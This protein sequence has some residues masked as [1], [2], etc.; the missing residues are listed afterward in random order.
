M[1]DQIRTSK[2]SLPGCSHL[3]Y[4]EGRKS[5]SVMQIISNSFCE[6]SSGELHITCTKNIVRNHTVVLHMA[7]VIK[8]L[9]MRS[10]TG[11][12]L[13]LSEESLQTPLLSFLLELGSTSTQVAVPSSLLTPLFSHIWLERT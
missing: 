9:R 3:L 7:P 13:Y 4:V 5:T 1:P 2:M 11:G 12:S 10:F 6:I 8:Q